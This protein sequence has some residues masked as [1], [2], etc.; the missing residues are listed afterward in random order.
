MIGCSWFFSQ[1]GHY[2]FVNIKGLSNSADF[3]RRRFVAKRSRSQRRLLYNHVRWGKGSQSVS[4]LVAWMI[5]LSFLTHVPL[6]GLNLKHMLNFSEKH[7]HLPPSQTYFLSKGKSYDSPYSELY[8]P[9]DRFPAVFVCLGCV[10]PSV[11]SWKW[12][13]YTPFQGH[14]VSSGQWS[15]PNYVLWDIWHFRV[16]TCKSP[17]THTHTPRPT[18]PAKTQYVRRLP[19]EGSAHW[20]AYMS[21][22]QV[23]YDQAVCVWE[24]AKIFGCM[25]GF[26]F[27]NASN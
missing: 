18:F 11:W 6:Q 22:S 21:C 26:V 20:C 17:P 1:W 12:L 23:I 25:K 10:Q 8:F 14:R 15:S 2:Q 24:A 13:W 7:M 4:S 3:P 5:M 19:S 27:T 16:F 9:A